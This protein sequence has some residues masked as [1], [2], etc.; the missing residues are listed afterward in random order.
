MSEPVNRAPRHKRYRGAQLV[1]VILAVLIIGPLFPRDL[2][3][4]PVSI[5]WGVAL[6]IAAGQISQAV[7]RANSRDRS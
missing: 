5:L 2:Y 3:D 6:G 1:G 4:S 7:A